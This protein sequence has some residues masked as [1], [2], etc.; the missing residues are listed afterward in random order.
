MA[1]LAKALD[2]LQVVPRHAAERVL[3]DQSRNDD[4]HGE[5]L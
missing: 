5:K 4:A 3:A 2:E 1:E